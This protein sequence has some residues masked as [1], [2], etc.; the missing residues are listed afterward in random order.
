M[1]SI[2]S[3]QVEPDQ[4]ER[5]RDQERD[6]PAPVFIAARRRWRDQAVD[7]DRVPPRTGQRA[8]LEEAAPETALAVGGVLGHERGRAAVLA[9]RGEALDD[10]RAGQQDRRQDADARRRREHYRSARCTPHISRIVVARTL[11]RPRR[12]PSGPQMNPPSGRSRNEMA[13]PSRVSAARSRPG[14]E[15]AA[16]NDGQ[17]G[18]EAVVEPFGGVA[19]R[20]GRHRASQ[21]RRR[22]IQVGRGVRPVRGCS[23]HSPL[24]GRDPRRPS[25]SAPEPRSLAD[26]AH[27]RE[28][29]QGRAPELVC[30]RFGSGTTPDPEAPT[31]PARSTAGAH[32]EHPTGPDRQEF[33]R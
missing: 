3:P 14:E 31:P 6:P 17:V 16:A 7:D 18:V 2:L 30:P 13:K 8:E 4:A 5:Q 26:G 22:H 1:S 27:G 33:V 15:L 12:S 10:R 9:A 29:E 21:L 20:G 24:S 11:W 23:H 32:V 25:T 19:D 28:P